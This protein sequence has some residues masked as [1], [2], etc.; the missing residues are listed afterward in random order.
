MFQQVVYRQWTVD[1]PIERV[2][3]KL[4][5]VYYDG[6]DWSVRLDEMWT[7]EE[8][9]WSLVEIGQQ[10]CQLVLLVEAKL[11]LRSICEKC[12]VHGEL[13]R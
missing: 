7:I 10:L 2:V 12:S 3:S 9:E 13:G 6:H 1:Y 4:G 5:V 11:Q 8:K